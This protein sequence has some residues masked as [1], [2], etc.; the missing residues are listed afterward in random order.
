MP[1]KIKTDEGFAILVN[2]LPICNFS[3]DLISCSQ[4]I[5]MDD[6]LIKNV[7]NPVNKFDAVNKDYASRIKYKTATG[8]ISKIAMTDH[9][10]FTFPAT[11][12]FTSGKMKIWKCWLNGWQMSG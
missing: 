9:I 6:N 8:I 3:Q 11:K 7:M 4:S 10:L 2:Q 1:V 5:D 12:A